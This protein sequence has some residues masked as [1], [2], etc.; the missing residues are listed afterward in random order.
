V[1]ATNQEN[2]KSI[3]SA[4]WNACVKL[5]C[6]PLDSLNAVQRPAA[7]VFEY[8]GRVQNGGHTLYFDC[9]DKEHDI[10]LI[11][12]LRTLGAHGQARILREARLLE[13]EASNSRGDEKGY[14]WEMIEDLDMQYGRVVPDILEVLARYFNA[15]RES[16]PK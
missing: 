2:Y 12:A 1:S 4:R 13:R 9:H 10:E 11:Q 16:F 14:L 6:L 5:L 7:L 3:D 8:D 15:H